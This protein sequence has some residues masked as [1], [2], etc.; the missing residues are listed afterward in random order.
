[1]LLLENL[2]LGPELVN[3][4]LQFLFLSFVFADI[5]LLAFDLGLDGLDA[6]IENGTLLVVS[7]TIGLQAVLVLC[8]LQAFL[9]GFELGL[10]VQVFVVAN[11]SV[12]EALAP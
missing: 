10:A 7:V 11:R 4:L 2:E 1:M 5:I 6:L 9:G 3:R 12:S 8:E